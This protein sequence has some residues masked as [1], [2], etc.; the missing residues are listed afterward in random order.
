MKEVRTI[1][2]GFLISASLA[3]AAQWL[4]T[5]SLPDAYYWH[6]LVYAS[7][8]LYNAGGS[9]SINGDID[10]S[11]VFYASVHE[12]GTIGPWNPT[13]PIP[14]PTLHH[15]SVAA[16]GFVYILAGYHFSVQT[17]DVL[18]NTV[19]RARIN[20]DGTL[21]PWQ[22]A[23]P[24]PFSAYGLGAS[25]WN[26]RIYVVGGQND[27][28]GPTNA[29]YSA[30][31]LSDGTLSAWIAQTPAPIRIAAHA[32][33]VNSMLYIIGGSTGRSGSQLNGKV[34][35]SAIN[36]DGT[37]A[38]WETNAL[39]QPLTDLGSIAARGQVL[40]VGGWSGSTSVNNYYS[41]AADGD[42]ALGPWSPG[43]SLPTALYVF[44]MAV[45][46]SH[47]FITGGANSAGAQKSV[48]SVALP[49]APPVPTLRAQVV[50][51]NRAFQINL[52]STSNT[53]FGLSASTDLVNWANIGWGFTDTN[54]SLALRDTNA[55]S[56]PQR[57]YRAY[58]PLP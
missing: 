37:L 35:Y 26:N 49:P 12:D 17:G 33:A 57:F 52:A 39:P 13:S 9:S 45:S 36:P 51:S 50:A 34:Y 24:I 58:W 29:V 46:D 30:V 42:G 15:A 38:G 31:I 43:P 54:G 28:V 7:G 14:Q 47:I 32:Q 55:A 48:R 11:H 18:T 40:I 1:I 10:G 56:F 20:Q 41:A 23:N 27:D 4:E 53:G 5:T 2:L 44:G 8:F 3:P 25:V 19:Y 16:N 21:A 22:V 6:S